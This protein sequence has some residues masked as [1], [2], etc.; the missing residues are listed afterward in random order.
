[1]KKAT[2]I[3]NEGQV[4]QGQNKRTIQKRETLSKRCQN[5]IRKHKKYKKIK[6]GVP[7]HTVQHIITTMN[8]KRPTMMSC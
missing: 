3:K 5:N 1:M 8:Y 6:K 7:L 4:T 2:F